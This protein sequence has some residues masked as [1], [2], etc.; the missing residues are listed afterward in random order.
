MA[1]RCRKGVFAGGR[2]GRLF[3]DWTTLHRGSGKT[4]YRIVGIGRAK[5]VGERR[6]DGEFRGTGRLGPS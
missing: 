6:D 1:M 5:M 2:D 3:D 4:P